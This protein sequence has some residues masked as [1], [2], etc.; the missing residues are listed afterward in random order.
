MS[1]PPVRCRSAK[2]NIRNHALRVNGPRRSSTNLT[3]AGDN[4]TAHTNDLDITHTALSDV[5]T[6]SN[7]MVCKHPQEENT[8]QPT[9]CPAIP[10]GR[11]GWGLPPVGAGCSSSFWTP[12][13]KLELTGGIGMPRSL[14][15]KRGTLSVC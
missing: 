13:E 9:R 5:N 12:G 6:P 1:Y 3:N 2:I 15:E 7:T 11:V 14:V 4:R 10:G 8:T